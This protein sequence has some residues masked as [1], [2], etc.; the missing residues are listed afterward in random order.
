MR[1]K[2]RILACVL[3][4]LMLLGLVA[5]GDQLFI[6]FQTPALGQD[7]FINSSLITHNSLLNQNLRTYNFVFI[8]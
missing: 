7:I 1:R 8:S 5:C 6:F 4:I 2:N 3:A